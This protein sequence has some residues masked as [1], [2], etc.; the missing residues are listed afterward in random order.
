MLSN[1][2]DTPGSIKRI[3]SDLG[4]EREALNLGQIKILHLKELGDLFQ[5]VF[6]SNF[7]IFSNVT[8]I[9]NQK[10]HVLRK[11][12]GVFVSELKTLMKLD[13]SHNVGGNDWKLVDVGEVLGERNWI[14]SLN[15][16]T[17]KLS[18]LTQSFKIALISND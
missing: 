15:L 2:S 17:C 9:L 1:N 13:L 10:T 11:I 4:L 6:D 12:Y 5:C 3:V 16:S 18:K 14:N 7:S 8:K